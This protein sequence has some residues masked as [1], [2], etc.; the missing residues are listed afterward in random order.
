MK[1]YRIHEFG[2]FDGLRLDELPTPSPGPGQV[3]VRVRAVSL[4]YRDLLVLKGFYNKNFPL[5]AVP[6]SDA[7]GEVVEVGDGVTRVKVGDRVAPIFMQTWLAGELAE[8]HGKSALGG[9][10]EGVLAEFVVLHENGLV[11]L[12]KHLSF[13]EGSTLPC[14]AVTAWNAL[15]VA[16][17]IKAGDTILTQGTGG[18]SLFA[19]QFA[20]LAGATVIATSSSDEKLERVLNMG[21]AAGINY[22]TT[23]DWEKRV[24]ELTGGRGV[25]L[26]VEVGGAGTLSKSLHAVRTAGQISL[27]GVLAGGAAEINTL[28][29]LM[30]AIEVRG[31]FVGSRAMFEAMNRALD[32]HE[33]R[34]V[35]DRVFPFQETPAA[36]RHMESAAHFGKIVIRV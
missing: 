31:I 4:N 33:L 23:P 2:G 11:L 16:G 26:V 7:A 20:K 6:L 30:R 17:N 13:E 35:I 14:A 19:L 18:V 10:T 21:A 34:P 22:K 15:F 9:A 29:I 25:D 12:P 24:R 5:P 36:F 1:T 3:L 32:A 27:I 28:P 8:A